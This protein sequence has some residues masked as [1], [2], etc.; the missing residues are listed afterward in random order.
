MK[1]TDELVNKLLAEIDSRISTFNDSTPAIQKQIF[2]RLQ[3][4]FKD[5]EL[6]GD[7]LAN[8]VDNIRAIGKLKSEIENIILSNK[9]IN[10]VADFTA[11]F[12]VISTLNNEYFTAMVKDFKRPA[13]LNAIKQDA[14][15]S[16]VVSLTE[17]G[18]SANVTEGIQDILRTNIRSGGMFTDLIEQMRTFIVGDKENLGSLEKHTRQI[19]TDSLNQYSAIYNQIISSDL[20][21]TWRMYVGSNLTTTR[22]FCLALTEKKYYHI[23]E[24]P[25]IIAGHIDSHTIPINSKTGVWPGGIPGTTVENFSNNRGGYNCGHQDFGVTEILV[26][27]NIRI[28]FYSS[29]GIPFDANGF[30]KRAA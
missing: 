1:Q 28:Q 14:I 13:V 9:Y 27:Q 16:T 4:L 18:I 23:D 22:K 11:A 2:E 12:N 19:T 25:E 29:R 8:S 26:P 5:L 17:A 7:R 30:M 15:K 3:T 24:L 10:Q 20:G 21:L 6:N